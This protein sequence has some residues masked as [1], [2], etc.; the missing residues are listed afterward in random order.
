MLDPAGPRQEWIAVW[1]HGR[2]WDCKPILYWLAPVGSFGFMPGLVLAHLVAAVDAG[3]SIMMWG[4]DP[5]CM[6][7]AGRL[8]GG[9]AGGGHA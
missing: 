8:V 3:R 2:D 5:E 7:E 9:L 6:A 4:S 1:P